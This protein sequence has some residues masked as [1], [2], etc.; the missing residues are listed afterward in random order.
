MESRDAAR[1]QGAGART[2]VDIEE[3]D[4]LQNK[5]LRKAIHARERGQCFY[6][7]RQIT[8]TVQCLDHV[9]PRAPLW[10]AVGAAHPVK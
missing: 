7:L 4:F 3:A 8:P 1:E 9:V 2:V 6:C 5:T 10:S